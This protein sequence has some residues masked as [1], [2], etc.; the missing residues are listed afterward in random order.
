VMKAKLEKGID[1]VLDDVIS[2]AHKLLNESQPQ[3]I[4]ELT[5]SQLRN[6][7]S[8]CEAT[9]SIMAVKNFI[10]YQMGRS[11]AWGKP[12]R[13]SFGDR[14]I[15]D[16]DRLK[17]KAKSIVNREGG[18]EEDEKNVWMELVRRYIGYLTRYFVYLE[19]L[20]EGKE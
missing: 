17:E 4:K 2:M 10:R 8:V 3:V 1:E 14:L 7:Q 13:E 20:R 9:N 6:L 5:T 16:L 15:G 11:N 12:P 18:S 19:S